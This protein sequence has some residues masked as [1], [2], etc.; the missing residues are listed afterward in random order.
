MPEIALHATVC[1][2]TIETSLGTT[3]PFC[4]TE[5][6]SKCISITVWIA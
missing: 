1:I 3:V 4:N 6:A 2:K 5:I